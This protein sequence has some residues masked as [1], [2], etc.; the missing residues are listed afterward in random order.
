MFLVAAAR[1]R[2]ITVRVMRF[3]ENSSA[4]TKTFVRQSQKG[5]DRVMNPVRTRGTIRKTFCI[6]WLFRRE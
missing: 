5:W 2:F 4:D 3:D 1:K 6:F